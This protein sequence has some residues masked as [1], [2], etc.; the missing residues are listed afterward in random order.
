MSYVCTGID[1]KT[2]VRIEKAKEDKT[3]IVRAK[4]DLNEIL[5]GEF[6]FPK[7][8]E[9]FDGDHYFRAGSKTKVKVP[10]GAEKLIRMD[11]V[12]RKES[13]VMNTI[14]LKARGKDYGEVINM[15][16]NEYEKLI[17]YLA[18]SQ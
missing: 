16:P 6:S 10:K 5:Y 13:P 4:T 2:K 14:Y 18:G 17:K 9:A 15:K 3:I 7:I 1:N 8:E 11:I 12:G